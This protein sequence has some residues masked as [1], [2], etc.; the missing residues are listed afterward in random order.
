MGNRPDEIGY[1]GLKADSDSKTVNVVG[2]K[3]GE[4]IVRSTESSEVPSSFSMTEVWR[5]GRSSLTW[6]TWHSGT[7]F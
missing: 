2:G 7:P 4:G 1:G 3:E 5:P 6:S